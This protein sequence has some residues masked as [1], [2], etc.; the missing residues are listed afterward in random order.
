MDAAPSLIGP[1]VHAS[2]L[3]GKLL[4]HVRAS[5]QPQPFGGYRSLGPFEQCRMTLSGLPD[6]AA[7]RRMRCHPKTPLNAIIGLTEMM[8]TNAARF[9]TEKALEPLR[10]VN[11]VL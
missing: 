1:P 7:A 9:G 10:R 6:G 3:V 4:K 8:V 11:D 5:A 2:W